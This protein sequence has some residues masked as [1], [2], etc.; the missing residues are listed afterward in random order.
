M[1]LIV[2]YILSTE[3]KM[4]QNRSSSMMK[5]RKGTSGYP[6][7]HTCP[8]SS[9]FKRKMGNYNWCKTTEKSMHSPYVTSIHFLLSW[10]P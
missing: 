6:S 4:K 8:L 3:Q 1:L 2:R 10:S 9:S 7:H 5:L